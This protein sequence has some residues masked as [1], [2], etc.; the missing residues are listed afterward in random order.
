MSAIHYTVTADE[1][2]RFPKDGKRREVVDGKTHIT[3]SPTLDHQEVTARV[4]ALLRDRVIPGHFGRVVLGPIDVRFSDQD[5]VKPDI[6]FI[7][8]ERRAICRE[9]SV[10]GAPDIVVEVLTPGTRLYDLTE[11]VALYE[12][13]FVPEYWIFDP[14]LFTIVHLVLADGR[15]Q[16]VQ[17]DENGLH[18]SVVIPDLVIDL[19]VL[20][21]DLDV[22]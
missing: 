1:L 2:A 14:N 21:A 16:R 13:F 12:R 9:D 4:N 5:L 8:A 11:K 7:R 10:H 20:F 18:R 22:W 17:P 3:H 19:K 6:I 15:Y